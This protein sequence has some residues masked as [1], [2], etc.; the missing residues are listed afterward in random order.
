MSELRTL[1]VGLDLDYHCSQL[2]YYNRKTNEPESIGPDDELLI[3]TAVGV[4]EQTKEWLYG[5]AALTC[6]EEEEGIAVTDMLKKALSEED[7]LIYD[8]AFKPEELMEK[9]LRRLLLLLKQRFPEEYI[10][11]LVVTIPELKLPLVR[12]VTRALAKMGLLKDRVTISSHGQSFQYYALHQKRELWSGNVAMF[13]YKEEGLLY[14][15]TSINRKR[16]P[17]LAALET[18]DYSRQIPFSLRLEKNKISYAFPNLA[19]QAMYRQMISTVYAVGS[20]FEG[21]W[22]ADCLTKLCVGRRVFLG[23]N[24]FAAGACYYALDL[25]NGTGS[26]DILYLT[27][28]MTVNEILCSVFY[29]GK[30]EEVILCDAGVNW[31]EVEKE[32]C[33]ILDDVESVEF[34]LNNILTGERRTVAIPLPGLEKRPRKMTRV[35][36]KLTYSEK[37]E[38]AILIEDQGF[39][40]F[41]PATEQ[42]WTEVIRIRGKEGA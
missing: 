8:V 29:K 26:D 6:Q 42:M 24:L 13:E 5:Q 3:P 25:E 32:Y 35:Q 22:A 41:Y 12:C 39:G 28:D 1:L 36:I 14:Y 18:A 15:Q 34:I 11:K 9:Y 2:C 40:E 20:G 38:L 23:Q 17:I 4:K 30:N 19:E 37:D 21:E 10:E 33:V 27:E 7:T 16:R 31:F